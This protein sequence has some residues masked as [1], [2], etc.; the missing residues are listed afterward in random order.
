MAA[1]TK[2]MLK[3]AEATRVLGDTVGSVMSNDNVVRVRLGSLWFG[4]QREK[5]EGE[6]ERKDGQ[7]RVV[8][9]AVDK[10]GIE[11][12][13]DFAAAS[14][15]E[16]Q[17]RVSVG[18]LNETYG[19]YATVEDWV[20]HVGESE[21]WYEIVPRNTA[22]W[23]YLDLDWDVEQIIKNLGAPTEEPEATVMKVV[24]RVQRLA[25]TM[26]EEE[27]PRE[28]QISC[29]TGKYDSSRWKGVKKASYHVVFRFG[30]EDQ[31]QGALFAQH[32]WKTLNDER[33]SSTTWNSQ[34]KKTGKW[35]VEPVMDKNPYGSN[36]SWRMLGSRKWGEKS[37]DRVLKAVMGSSPRV[38]DHMV[39]MYS[40]EA[41]DSAAFV[42]MAVAPRRMPTVARAAA[43]PA[44]ETGEVAASFA[45]ED[46]LRV[47]FELCERVCLGLPEGALD[48][49]KEWMR[50]AVWGLTN[51]A[52]ENEYE[53][54]AVRELSHKVSARSR[55]YDPAALDGQ[56]DRCQPRAG[57]ISWPSIRSKLYE[58]NPELF[59]DLV[60]GPQQVHMRVD[61]R[62]EYARQYNAHPE[63]HMDVITELQVYSAERVK[64]YNFGKTDVIVV[65]AGCGRGK[66]YQTERLLKMTRKNEF[67]ARYP[68]V[69][70]LSSRQ[71]FPRSMVR[72]Y[73][74]MLAEHCDTEVDEELLFRD[75]RKPDEV[76]MEDDEEVDEGE[77]GV[78]DERV[79]DDGL[80]EENEEAASEEAA[81]EEDAAREREL[82][83]YSR[84]GI[85]MESLFKLGDAEYD[86]LLVDESETILGQFT[87]PTMQSRLQKC[88]E[89]FRRLLIKTPKIVVMDA[90]MTDKTLS[91]LRHLKSERGDMRV[92]CQINTMVKTGRTARRIVGN[93]EK[94]KILAAICAKLQAGKRVVLFSTSATFGKEAYAYI[95]AA[96][97]GT[98]TRLYL[99]KGD[100]RL[101]KRELGMV[102]RSWK[103]LDCL[104]Y[105]PVL[106]NGVS[107][108][109]AK[110]FDVLFMYVTNT[111]CCIRD[112]FQA[113]ARVR[114]YS[115]DV[116]YYVLKLEQRQTREVLL[117]YEGVLADVTMRGELQ[118]AYLGEAE[119]ADPMR[120]DGLGEL[121]VLLDDTEDIT[122][123]VA[124][125]EF[126]LRARR[127]QLSRRLT[128]TPAMLLDIHVRN[129]LEE[130]MTR[131]PEACEE[132]FKAMLEMTG[133]TSGED[134]TAEELAGWGGPPAPSRRRRRKAASDVSV[135]MAYKDIECNLDPAR[136]ET[137]KRKV[138]Q[139][140]AS[141]EESQALKRHWFDSTIVGERETEESLR[142]AVFNGMQANSRN[143]ETL[144]NVFV[145]LK[146]GDV[147]E[148]ERELSGNP[149]KE[150]LPTR[151]AIVRGM[152][153]LCA[154]LGLEHALDT[155]KRFSEATLNS[156][157]AGVKAI[158]GELLRLYGKK[159]RAVE[160]RHE[161]KTHLCNVL[162]EF[163][164]CDLQAHEKLHKRDGRVEKSYKY[165]VRIKDTYA[166]DVGRLLM[167]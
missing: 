75:Y 9:R 58:V 126:M 161:L 80:S 107:F 5:R 35:T 138:A 61:R 34:D 47:P 154:A 51:M 16:V 111:S 26:Y 21:H 122:E 30:F 64:A 86:L 25:D 92:S 48:D 20:S 37:R 29:A 125:E 95:A 38:E 89:T 42:R 129:R 50:I 130:N 135:T 144:L 163:C 136:E 73:N 123:D 108:D 2:V 15:H 46:R 36:Q 18:E 91:V 96:S 120:R 151:W 31:A 159:S 23:F 140:E 110:H 88:F 54:A 41:R 19:S 137:L 113:S 76:E 117:T 116:M 44:R 134:V 81:S 119:R 157:A 127:T 69:L 7:G 115:E 131:Y 155:S 100:A 145:I 11:C 12:M 28:V 106:L 79:S 22:R 10:K 78:S 4:N 142:A 101:Q 13:Q 124:M 49:Y 90:Y 24:D 102:N 62:H 93:N 43:R 103:A 133:F 114:D 156:E 8:K 139:G 17:M 71:T 39:V 83:E 84:M 14:E 99:G 60:Q 147:E 158:V 70:A 85:Q 65:Q 132:T 40:A 152:K 165:S 146:R 63:E 56:L 104:I 112:V 68:R 57:G 1:T 160:G 59:K 143:L 77:E 66:T 118:A 128:K 74:R 3:K 164:G 52:W 27:V 141:L 55:G 32:A 87:S 94:K 166:T 97:P 98:V 153:N 82:G 67:V 121:A 53:K 105:S 148:A 150:M 33:S 162:G 72:R 6:V 167:V 45:V 109:V 149:Y